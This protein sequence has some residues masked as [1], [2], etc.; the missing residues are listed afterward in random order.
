M[1]SFTVCVHL[2]K[3]Y[4]IEV[5]AIKHVFIVRFDKLQLRFAVW[6]FRSFVQDLKGRKVRGA[7]K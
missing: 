1:G 4:H 7:R 6:S 2:M 5:H 3:S